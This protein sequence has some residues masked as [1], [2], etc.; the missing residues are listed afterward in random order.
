MVKHTYRQS[1]MTVLVLLMVVKSHWCRASASQP[2]SSKRVSDWPDTLRLFGQSFTTQFGSPS[3][4]VCC[5]RICVH[6]CAVRVWR[7]ES[8]RVVGTAVTWKVGMHT[9]NGVIPSQSSTHPPSSSSLPRQT[10]TGGCR[11]NSMPCGG[12]TGGWG[13][14]VVDE[15][16]SESGS[17]QPVSEPAA[18]QSARSGRW[19]IL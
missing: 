2:S 16:P 13:D 19:S 9:R 5:T 18:N 10:R 15:S 8:H 4:N 17:H 3:T 12:G 1:I 14:I 7:S 6:S 11:A